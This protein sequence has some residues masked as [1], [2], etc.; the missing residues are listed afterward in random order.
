LEE[1]KPLFSP[2]LSF[3]ITYMGFKRMEDE[4]SMRGLTMNRP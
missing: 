3:T 4:F 2:I 1:Y